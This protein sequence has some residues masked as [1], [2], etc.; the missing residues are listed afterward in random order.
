MKEVNGGH[1]EKPNL[2]TRSLLPENQEA[3]IHFL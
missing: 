2:M 3:P 1:L